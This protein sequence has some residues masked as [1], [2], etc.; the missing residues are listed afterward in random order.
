[1]DGTENF[2]SLS[3][4]FTGKQLDDDFAEVLVPALQSF[5]SEIRRLKEV[6]VANLEPIIPLSWKKGRDSQ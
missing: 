3:A 4:S 6:D 1:M 5:F 2:K